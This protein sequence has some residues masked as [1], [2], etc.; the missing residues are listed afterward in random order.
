MAF[1]LPSKALRRLCEIRGVLLVY[2]RYSIYR[3][4]LFGITLDSSSQSAAPDE[5]VTTITRVTC[6]AAYLVQVIYE[7]LQ[8]R[9]TKVIHDALARGVLEETF[10]SGFKPPR[11]PAN[12]AQAGEL[13][14]DGR[15]VSGSLTEIHGGRSLGERSK[16]QGAEPSIITSQNDRPPS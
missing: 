16:I 1:Y 13:T 2:H 15:R 7:L 14:G 4:K 6:S 8:F 5:V 11:G 9:T 3:A 12:L 10:K